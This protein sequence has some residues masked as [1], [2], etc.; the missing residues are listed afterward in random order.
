MDKQHFQSQLKELYFSNSAKVNSK[1]KLPTNIKNTNNILKNIVDKNL[2]FKKVRSLYKVNKILEKIL[3]KQHINWLVY[4][5]YNKNTLVIFVQDHI[6]QNEFN[7]QK[8]NILN[9]FK[10]L[11]EYKGIEKVSILRDNNKI[12][13]KYT[14]WQTEPT[15]EKSFAIFDN[16]CTNKT[17]S[18][19]IEHI[20][21]LILSNQQ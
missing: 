5:Y 13:F 9:H 12:D 8:T 18:S 16:F 14:K 1:T 19:Q 21:Q 15:K 4:A 20:R 10:Q 11:E 2:P 6:A 7:Y 3:L 17:L